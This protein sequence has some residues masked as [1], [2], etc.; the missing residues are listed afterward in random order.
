MKTNIFFTIAAISAMSF[1]ACNKLDNPTYEPFVYT[2]ENAKINLGGTKHMN[3]PVACIELN[4][5]GTYIAEVPADNYTGINK[6]LQIPFERIV[7]GEKDTAPVTY[8]IGNYN[9]GSDAYNLTNFG[10]LSFEKDMIYANYTYNGASYRDRTGI[11]PAERLPQFTSVAG[12]W[13]PAAVQVE[14]KNVSTGDT[15]EKEY[16]G[17]NLE[18][19]ASDVAATCAPGLAEYLG[20]FKGYSLAKLYVSNMNTFIFNYANGASIGGYWKFDSA[21]SGNVSKTLKDGRKMDVG[22][23]YIPSSNNGIPAIQ[24][25]A[26]VR[27]DGVTAYEIKTSLKLK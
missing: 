19:I 7:V 20:E 8:V 3:G 21:K 15:F 14:V 10:S 6:Y 12:N 5:D 18:T 2:V 22:A 17:L 13:T 11:T 24:I 16:S 1:A 4:A 26:S 25:N 9:A 27:I 23:S